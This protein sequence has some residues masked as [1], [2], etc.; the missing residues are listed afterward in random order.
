[1]NSAL[2]FLVAGLLRSASNDCSTF[3]CL[4]ARMCILFRCKTA[5]STSVLFEVPLLN[6]FIVVLLLPNAS[7]KEKG[8]SSA[9]KG[10]SASSDTASSISTGFV[11]DFRWRLDY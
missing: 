11:L 2:F 4:L 6:F 10:C 9:S 1:M 8:N 3:P 5:P 7:K